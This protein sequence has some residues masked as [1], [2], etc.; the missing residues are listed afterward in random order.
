MIINILHELLFVVT[1]QIKKLIKMNEKCRME[2]CINQINEKYSLKI[3]SYYGCCP[4]YP[5][6]FCDEQCMDKFNKQY[7]CQRCHRTSELKIANDELAYCMVRIHDDDYL[8]CYD[9]NSG[10]NEEKIKEFMEIY[11]EKTKNL[12]FKFAD[13][14][15]EDIEALKSA[16]SYA[17]EI[18]CEKKY[19][20]EYCSNNKIEQLKIADNDS[21]YCTYKARYWDQS[22]YDKYL[23][24]SQDTIDKITEKVN[25]NLEFD[26]LSDAE[27]KALKIIINERVDERV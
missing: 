8:T 6:Y 7:R 25:N 4:N 13:F 1:I 24:I 15:N 9:L 10:A 12:T 20:C 22:C 3:K 5:V 26:E 2:G 19:V 14:S 18:Q 11:V 17:A 16:I 23:K 27:L 21:I